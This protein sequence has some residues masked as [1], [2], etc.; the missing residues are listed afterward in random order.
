MEEEEMGVYTMT[1][2]SLNSADM[3][4]FYPEDKERVKNIFGV[5]LEDTKHHAEL[6]KLIVE[7]GVR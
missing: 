1:L 2:Y 6:L 4:Y 3:D 5:L 7:I